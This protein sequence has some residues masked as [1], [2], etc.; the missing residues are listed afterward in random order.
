MVT[1]VCRLLFLLLLIPLMSATILMTTTSYCISRIFIVC[2]RHE[3]ACFL[4][5]RKPTLKRPRV[6]CSISWSRFQRW[7]ALEIGHPTFK[8]LCF[9]T[10]FV[11]G[12]CCWVTGWRKGIKTLNVERFLTLTWAS[13]LFKMT[14]ALL[15]SA[16][17]WSLIDWSPKFP[18]CLAIFYLV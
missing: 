8:V 14:P 13:C 16:V 15:N 5:H 17:F 12:W 7:D 9:T 10:C 1:D 18:S 2:L 3:V 11:F 6:T 4:V